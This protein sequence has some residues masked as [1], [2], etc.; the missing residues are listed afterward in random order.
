M[1]IDQYK[2]LIIAGFVGITSGCLCL[3]AFLTFNHKSSLLVVTTGAV[4]GA[5]FICWVQY[6]FELNLFGLKTTDQYAYLAIEL[7]VD[8]TKPDLYQRADGRRFNL[9]KV[10]AE[11]QANDWVTS[12]RSE[13]FQSAQSRDDL[14]R[15]FV[16][17]SFLVYLARTQFNWQSVER[18]FESSSMRN[19]QQTTQRDPSQCSYF[20]E[21]KF[22]ARLLEARNAFSGASPVFIQPDICLPPNTQLTVNKNR[23]VIENYFYR[24][25]IAL[26]ETSH[27]AEPDQGTTRETRVIHATLLR[28]QLPWR[29]QHVESDRYD[30]WAKRTFDG[31]R[32]WFEGTGLQKD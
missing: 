12:R 28:R 1:P 14:V 27:T 16:V 7:G 8:L 9:L 6:V 29:S 15:D 5:L 21:A 24:V 19:V 32:E 3:L 31:A 26:Q 10:S 13:L 4:C 11:R 18:V 30:G 20:D 17:Y 22:Q 25:S 23:V 2:L